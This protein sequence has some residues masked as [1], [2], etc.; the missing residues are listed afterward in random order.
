MGLTLLRLLLLP[1][2]LWMLLID[3]G[4]P[5][6]PVHRHRFYA[7]GIFAVMAATDKLDGYLARRLNQTSKLGETLDPVADKLLIACSVILL[8]FEWVAP[9]GFAIPI[10]VV[11]AVYGKD[12]I[13]AI[14]TLMLLW[15]L[16]S[17]NIRPRALGKLSTVLQLV[18][19]MATLVARDLNRV[20]PALG[21]RL[22]PAL[23]WGVTVVAVASCVDYV[24]L[25]VRTYRAARR[26]AR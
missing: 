13:V 23:W 18:M 19:I 12:L 8:S 26:D 11:G 7:L 3:A 15:R 10:W 16:H 1:I 5:G 17:V 22:L 6:Q 9:L 20:R 24:A 14:G 4:G 21:D 2:F 25:G